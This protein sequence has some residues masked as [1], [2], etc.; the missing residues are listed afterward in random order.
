MFVCGQGK[1]LE[2]EWG[3]AAPSQPSATILCPRVT[4]SNLDLNQLYMQ[5][6][7]KCVWHVMAMVV[8]GSVAFLSVFHSGVSV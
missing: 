4:C 5:S 7:M 2:C 8:R 3:L 6:K 1:E